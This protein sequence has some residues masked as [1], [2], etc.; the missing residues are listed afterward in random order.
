MYI[1]EIH[2]QI[3]SSDYKPWQVY[4]LAGSLLVCLGIYYEI[5][6]V[7]AAL[8]S[9]E[10]AT[11]GLEWG[12]ILAIQG[13]IIGFTAEFLYEQGDKYAKA[14]SNQFGL[15]DRTL[16]VRVGVMTVVSAVINIL[17]PS[18]VRGFTQYIVI[19]TTGAVI[20]LGILLVHQGSKEWNPMTEWPALLSGT[21]LAIAPS[22]L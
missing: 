8:R 1:Q 22:L 12:V 2:Q 3:K 13:I 21:L 11:S 17:V 7:T 10:A 5:G 6:F 16:L 14:G 15:R 18:L 19:Q 4:L 9:M 20:V